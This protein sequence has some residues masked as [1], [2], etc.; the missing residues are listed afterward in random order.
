MPDTGLFVIVSGF[1]ETS[2]FAT[3]P[4]VQTFVFLLKKNISS[5]L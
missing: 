4:S 5:A 1:A 2:T 3:F